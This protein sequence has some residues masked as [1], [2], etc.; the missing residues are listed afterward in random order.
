MF[1]QVLAYS[2]RSY[3]YTISFLCV[4]I[5]VGIPS[6]T[7]LEWE[8]TEFTERIIACME[9]NAPKSITEYVCP[10][11]WEDAR[12]VRAYQAAVSLIF[13]P[14]DR[15][16]M[17]E[18]TMLTQNRSKNLADWSETTRRFSSYPSPDEE[19]S[20]VAQ[21][22]SGCTQA[23]RE[24]M[25]AEGLTSDARVLENLP[26]GAW[27]EGCQALVTRK[28]QAYSD[29]AWMIA[30]RSVGRSYSND[31][32]V[33]MNETKNTYSKLLDNLNRYVKT[34]QLAAKKV[35]ARVKVPSIAP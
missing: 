20:F 28:M 19:K 8:K 13:A 33:W 9:T 15:A 18:L 10:Q 23:I 5:G 4:C 32:N 26:D 7:A 35:N 30:S 21:Y 27:L 29:M 14:I 17:R 31:Y 24:V 1:S 11:V 22:R 34:L 2:S 3:I 16:V 6:L 25:I 12:A